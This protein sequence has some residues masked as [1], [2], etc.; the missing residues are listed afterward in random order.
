MGRRK[1]SEEHKKNRKREYERQ[2]TTH[3]YNT[4]DEYRQYR[5]NQMKAY[6]AKKKLERQNIVNNNNN[7]N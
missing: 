6:N 1:L 7:D 3:R 5:I 2:Y 4:D